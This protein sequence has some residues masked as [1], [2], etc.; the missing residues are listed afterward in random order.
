[1]R[2]SYPIVYPS[3][4]VVELLLGAEVVPSP[5][6]VVRGIDL[7]PSLVRAG[8]LFQFIQV[9]NEAAAERLQCISELPRV[10][11]MRTVDPI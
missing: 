10:F 7:L 11:K 3:A 4:P 5:L 1:M 2:C 8:R 9:P 6:A